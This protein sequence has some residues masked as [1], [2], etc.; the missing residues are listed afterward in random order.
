M[1]KICFDAGI[2]GREICF[3]VDYEMPKR[4][5]DPGLVFGPTDPQPW[6]VLN[7]AELL[8][9]NKHFKGFVKN[10]LIDEKTLSDVAN[11]GMISKLA[12]NLSDGFQMRFQSLLKESVA[13]INEQNKFNANIG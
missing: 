3:Y 9:S 13:Q 1:A 11:L 4:P 7:G 2:L 10:G 12:A 6:R 5:K 8:E